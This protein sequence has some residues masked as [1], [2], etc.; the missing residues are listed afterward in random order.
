[1]TYEY[2][3]RVSFEANIDYLNNTFGKNPDFQK[4]VQTTKFTTSRCVVVMEV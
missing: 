2:R 3:D 1:M 4:L